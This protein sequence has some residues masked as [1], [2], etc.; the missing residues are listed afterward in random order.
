M[1]SPELDEFIK[2]SLRIRKK[3]PEFSEFIY[4]ILLVKYFIPNLGIKLLNSKNDLINCIIDPNS[5]KGNYWQLI[6]LKKSFSIELSK[7]L[8]KYLHNDDTWWNFVK[9]VPIGIYIIS[10]I[11]E[12]FEEEEIRKKTGSFFTQ[13]SQIQ[14][15]CHYALFYY[16]K[17]NKELNIQDDTI[18]NIVFKKNYPKKLPFEAYSQINFFLQKIKVID[19]SCGLGTFLI[20][21]IEIILE[22]ILNN[23]LNEHISKDERRIIIENLFSNFF[24]FD[25]N[26]KSVKIAKIFLMNKFFSHCNFQD[27]EASIDVFNRLNIFHQDFLSYKRSKNEKFDIFIGNPPFVRHHDLSNSKIKRNFLQEFVS[28]FPDIDLKWDLKADLY[29]YFWI[30]AMALTSPQ[31]VVS[32]V[33]SRAWL[34]SRYTI[35]IFQIFKHYFNLDLILEFPFE[36]W[37]NVEVRT[38]ILV[39]HKEETKADNKEIKLFIW[40]KPFGKLLK[41]KKLL[42]TEFDKEVVILNTDKAEIKI[43][44]FESNSYRINQISNSILF[45][46]N[47]KGVFPFLR[48]DYLEMSPFILMDILLKNKNK[49]CLLKDLGRLEMG[50]TTGA[51]WFFYLDEKAVKKWGI[52]P[53]YLHPMTKSP[54]DWETICTINK[55]KIKYL[56]YIPERRRN[57]TFP[58]VLKYLDSHQD[59]ILQRPYFKNKTK[60]NWF[61]IPLIKPDLLIPNM[62]YKR[63]FT[64]KNQGLHIDKQWIGF[65]SNNSNWNIIILAFL[66]SSLGILLREIQG[67]KTLGLGSLKLS[68]REVE[69]LLILDPRKFPVD[70]IND[71]KLLINKLGKVKVENIIQPAF[72]NRSSCKDYYSIRAKIDLLILIDYMNL[73]QDTIKKINEVLEFEFNWRFAKE[74]GVI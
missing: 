72:I 6:W 13:K 39:G 63:S 42:L 11:Y 62:I 26:S 32:F 9:N 40:K 37:R 18:F 27:S 24:G 7:N 34:S 36:V 21:M 61:R 41:H 50:S 64:A 44:A 15:L 2:N 49:F 52:P 51:N 56:F 57:Q 23:P 60:D 68:L 59:L 29:I 12:S 5:A 67:T 58:Q 38:H 65:W 10:D 55:D 33:T 69:N 53:K 47:E 25:I 54:K 19:P 30:K 71:L 22:L 74:F 16:F 46:S 4:F 14:V 70:L 73:K 66:N 35:P 31:G 3:I 28:F 20:E 17:N 48:L 1:N 8:T 43:R 45:F